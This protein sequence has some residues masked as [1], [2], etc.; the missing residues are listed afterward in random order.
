MI[1]VQS[2][3]S[4]AELVS[5]YRQIA[6]TKRKHGASLPIVV[7]AEPCCFPLYYKEVPPFAPA[8]YL[9]AVQEMR[10]AGVTVLWYVPTL[11]LSREKEGEY[12]C[13]RCIIIQV[14]YDNT[15]HA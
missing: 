15:T 5:V 9:P 8:D 3:R 11:D 13:L 4:L 12:C 1:P 10:E 6:A 14:L 7:Q 2:G